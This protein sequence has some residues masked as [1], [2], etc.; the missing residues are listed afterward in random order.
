MKLKVLI[1]ESC[2]N[3]ELLSVKTTCVE[4]ISIAG[5]KLAFNYLKCRKLLDCI[6]VCHRVLELYPDYP[7]IKRDI[8]DKARQSLR[9]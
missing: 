7:R 8:M 6:E 9:T 2:P 1:H 4:E 5:Y 3:V